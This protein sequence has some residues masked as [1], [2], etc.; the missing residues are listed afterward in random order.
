MVK[1]FQGILFFPVLGSVALKVL[2][3]LDSAVR[4]QTDLTEGLSGNEH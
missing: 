1:Y 3:G 4:T 2:E